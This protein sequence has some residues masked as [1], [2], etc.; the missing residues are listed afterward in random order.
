ML[1]LNAKSILLAGSAM[2]VLALPGTASAQDAQGATA[3]DTGS[4]GGELVVVARRSQTADVQLNSSKPI[5]VLSEEDL[6]HTAVHNVAEALGLMPGVNVMNTGSS[7][8]GGIDG[9][10]R[11]EGMFVSIRG[12]NA[13]YNVNLINGV[14]VAQGMPYS[15]Q[16]KLSLLPPS[17][18]NTI[19]LNKVSSADMDGDA[20]GGTVDFRTPTAYDYSQD[21]HLAVTA[22]GRVETRARDYDDSGLGGGFSGEI[23]KRFGSE[24]QFG[25]Y[26]SGYFD[27]RHFANSEMAGA[28]AAQSDGGWGYLAASDADGTPYAGIDPQK[29]V[30]QTGVNIGVSNGYTRR[31]GGNA[32]LDWHPDDT[33]QIYLRGTYAYAK[34]EQNSTFSQYAASSKSYNELVPGSGRYALSVDQ[35]STRVWYETNPEIAK[36]ATASLGGVKE[37]GSWTISPQVFFSEGHNDRPG[38]IEASIRNNQSDNYN[39]GSTSPLGGLSMSYKDNLPQPL[40]TPEILDQLDNAGDVLLARRAGQYTYQTSGQTKWGGRLDLE[41]KFE[42]SALQSIKFGGKYS[43]SS[44]KVTN[45]DWTNDHFANL[46]GEAGVTWADLGIV[47]GKYDSVF[48]GVYNWSVPKVDQDKLKEYFF[49]YQTAASFDSCG[50]NLSYTDNLNC[51]TQRGSERVA[52]GYVMANIQSGDLEVIPGLRFEHTSID[53]T[54]WVRQT[55]ADG[56]PV[57]GNFETNHTQYN[58][59]LPSLLVNYR[60]TSDSVYRGS[61][62]WSYT[63]PAFVQLGGGSQVDVGDTT[64]TIT[65]GNPNLKPVKSLNIDVSGEWK[66][67]QSGYLTLGGYYK[68]L[69]NYL[70]DNGSGYVNGNELPDNNVITIMPQN[71]GSGDVYGLE[72]QFRKKFTEAPGILGGFGIG[73]SL[74]RQWTKVDIGDGVQKRIQNAPSILGDAQ[75]F[76]EQGRFSIDMIYHY[77]GEYVS[78]YNSLGLGTWDDTWIRPI[79]T[80]DLHAG[81]DFGGGIRADLSVANLFGAYT[82][83]AHIG[84]DTLA[85]SDVVDSGTTALMTVKF[86]F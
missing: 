23:A 54:Y 40:F 71:G 48:P 5:S 11:G 81:Y 36:L 20:I 70:Y 4:N 15:R 85:L 24:G 9:A 12:L 28:A 6:Q 72:M 44:R 13:E 47:N 58:E 8:F 80:V 64:T 30:T 84:R 16:V 46:L 61:V 51:N 78:S 18:L 38:H 25:I 65:M 7:F 10:S 19:V 55:D 50:D 42:G 39:H 75:L 41:R 52:A 32:S 63:R 56:N 69:S 37:A 17:G 68:H 14:N 82:Y 2:L 34:T 73:G 21:F 77:S 83:W 66:I 57:T 60:P 3:A 27:E 26:A 22:S 1:S 74:T 49:K 45:R 79:Q 67:T 29:N 62:W 35:I 33:T 53:N 31:W 43:D 86:A 59:L 76:W